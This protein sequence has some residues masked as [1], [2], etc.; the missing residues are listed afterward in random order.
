MTSFFDKEMLSQIIE[1]ISNIVFSTNPE[2]V[3]EYV[4]QSFTAVTGYCAEE[5]T[6]KKASI[7]K[8]GLMDDD[9]Y[10]DVWNTILSGRTVKAVVTNRR[11][12]GSLF[13]YNQTIT[14]VFDE[15][16]N[17]AHFV[18]T[19]DDVS[20]EYE[21]KMKLRH[22]QELTELFVKHS[23]A[24]VAMFDR[25]LRYLITS[26]QWLTDYSLAGQEVI[27]KTHYEVFPEIENRQDWKEYHRRALEG[28]G[29]S[30]EQD[31]FRRSDGKTDWIRWSLQ[32]WYLEN[33][34]VGGIIMFTQLINEQKALLEKLEREKELSR[35]FLEVAGTMFVVLDRS[36]SVV[37]V[38]K[39]VSEI[40]G[41]SRR[42]LIG[43]NWFRMIIPEEKE[44]QKGKK[45][46]TDNRIIREGEKFLNYLEKSI[47]TKSGTRRC[48][49][50]FNTVIRD[51]SGRISHTI[52]SGHDITDRLRSEEELRH[53]KENLESIISER[54]RSLSIANHTLT[55]REAELKEATRRAE[56]ANRA[57]TMF[58]TNMSHEIRTPLNSIIGFTQLLRKDAANSPDQNEK[59]DIIGR[60]SDHLLALI[61]DIL[62]ISKIE[63]GKLKLDRSPF[64]LHELI[65]NLE[66]MFRY[67]AQ[68]EGLSLKIEKEADIPEH[69]LGDARKLRQL[70]FNLIS[71]ALK[72]T[73]FGEI[74][75]SLG[76]EPLS[77]E[78]ILLKGSVRDSGT[79]I[80]GEDIRT[81]FNYFEQS[82]NQARNRGGTGLGLA[83]AKEIVELMEGSISAESTPG[84]GSTFSFEVK[85]DL[86]PGAGS[87]LTEETTC[88][89]PEENSETDFHLLEENREVLI[90][91]DN[92][93]NRKLLRIL[94]ERTGFSVHEAADG[95]EGLE[96]FLKNSFR[97]VFADL[98]MPVMDGYGFARKVRAMAQEKNRT[99][100]IA[101][102]AAFARDVPSG[103][104]DALLTKPIRDC[105]LNNVIRKFFR[106]EY[107]AP[108]QDY[109][110]GISADLLE[111]VYNSAVEGDIYRLHELA[112]MV[113]SG[114]P[115]AAAFILEKTDKF[116]MGSIQNAFTSQEELG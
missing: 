70:F 84:A 39:K 74:V 12:D 22:Q 111:Q 42:E 14:P 23:P 80:S 81:I 51:A 52:S 91:D 93:L 30:R 107:S 37:L 76:T 10:A 99:I 54:T 64:N 116:D 105:D 104:F 73:D 29:I 75:V 45:S 11:K 94:L 101:V 25:D 28:E 66:S 113:R 50:W 110:Q 83:I 102:T 92:E 109:R 98:S 56:E 68:P 4:N 85:L 100:I 78:R 108:P 15:E 26:D 55:E 27:G 79:G 112:E 38:N 69:V 46:L 1:S 17:I 65:A 43:K 86:Y 103:L 49:G 95:S 5:A 18:S 9:Y 48:I 90:L 35:L 60:S 77:E 82:H 44:K 24:A 6:G 61:D 2:G 20:A 106:V 96:L 47:T 97:A 59:L 40:L 31:A 8:S 19:G 58:L 41:Y 57:K 21:A 62:E 87:V 67:R 34:E 115:E 53:H 114:N 72:Y 16:G 33:G 32:P 7:L 13:Y 71:N 89:D 63:A 88:K 36:G 3:I